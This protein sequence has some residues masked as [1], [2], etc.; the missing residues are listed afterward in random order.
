MSPQTLE[1]VAAQFRALA[2]PTRLA[3]LQELQSGELSVNELTA[4]AGFSQANTSKHL[5]VLYAADFLRRRKQGTTVLY[6]IADPMVHE[7]CKLMCARVS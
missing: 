6:S 7:L 3:L 4:A 2:E 1:A 5:A